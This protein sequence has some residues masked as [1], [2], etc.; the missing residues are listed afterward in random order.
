[1]TE[2]DANAYGQVFA[3]LL[4]GSRICELGPGR[5]NASM[6]DQLSDL[7]VD[8]AFH[9]RPIQDRDMALCCLSGVWLLHDYLDESHTISQKI[10]S[11]TGSY[12]HGIMHRREPD[13][14]NAKYWF[15]RV[16]QHPIFEPLGRAAKVATDVL[17]LG[18]RTIS[19]SDEHAWDPFRFVDLCQSAGG[20]APQD[21]EWC[22]VAA[23]VEWEF[24]FD[25]CFQCAVAESV[26]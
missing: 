10:D 14:S 2:F 26:A 6:Y 21:V 23:R 8:S 11:T 1:M 9:G 4:A 25:Y 12:W 24:L 22:Q 15:R 3:R 5:P 19:L 18:G 16:G 13:Y 17:S 7:T 20:G